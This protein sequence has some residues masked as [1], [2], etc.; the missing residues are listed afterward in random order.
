MNW[1]LPLSGRKVPDFF[2]VWDFVVLLSQNVYHHLASSA[3][4]F[5]KI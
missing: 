4:S 3:C 2:E 5:K 1:M